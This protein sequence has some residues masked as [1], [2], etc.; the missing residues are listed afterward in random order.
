[1]ENIAT[2]IDLRQTI[3][4]FWDTVPTVWNLIRSHLRTIATEQFDISVGQFHVLRHIR[5]G[6]TSVRD[7][8]DVRQ[9]SR[10]AVSQEV[11]LL[12][13]KGLITRCQEVDDRRF[14]HLA[15]TPEGEVLLNQVFQ[16]NRAWMM[17]KMASISNE[18]L[19]LITDGLAL[20][21]T[22]F[23]EPTERTQENSPTLIGI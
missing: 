16:Q 23:T 7:I 10:P 4:Q 18:D 8:A 17:E 14:V 22:A 13:E 15:L 12:V 11:D 19:G 1:M 6:L 2:E 9:I 5:K 21:K 3:D 20:L